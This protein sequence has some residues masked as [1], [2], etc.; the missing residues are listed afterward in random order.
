MVAALIVLLICLWYLRPIL[1]DRVRVTV[2]A[3]LGMAYVMMFGP[4]VERPTLALFGV[5][6]SWAVMESLDLPRARW[7]GI[8]GYVC[9]T[10]LSWGLCQRLTQNRWPIFMAALPVGAFLI[11]VWTVLY[12]ARQ[13]RAAMACA[14]EAIRGIDDEQR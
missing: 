13:R 3:T 1:S 7:L 14:R 2:A 11:L 10:V 12:A 4:A 5:F 9:S 6:S 8:G